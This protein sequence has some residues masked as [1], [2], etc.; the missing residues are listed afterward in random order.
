MNKKEEE[1]VQDV[2]EDL[3][4]IK[5]LKIELTK[6]GEEIVDDLTERAKKL[7]LDFN[8]F[9]DRIQDFINVT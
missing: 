5:R 9:R 1:Q 6:E 3:D 2:I 4:A 8:L 7:K